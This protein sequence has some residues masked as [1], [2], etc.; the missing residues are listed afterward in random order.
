MCAMG[1]VGIIAEYNPFHSGHEYHIAETRRRLGADV[2]VVAVMSGNWVQR[3]ECAIADKWLRARWAVLGG[4]DLV[5]EL[6]TVFAC[7]PAETFAGSAVALLLATGVVDQ[8][9]FG[10]EAGSGEAL[11]EVARCLN[12]REYGETL[13]A[14]RQTPSRTFAQCRQKAVESLLGEER[15]ILLS[16]PNCNLA[17]EYLRRCEEMLTPLAI[18]RAGAGHDAEDT[19]QGHCSASALRRML[20]GGS[21][22]TAAPFLPYV[23]Q[24]QPSDM[25]WGERAVLAKLRTMTERAWGELL[26]S[27]EKEGLPHRLARGAEQSGTL[28]EFYRVVKTKRYT[29]ARIRRLTLHAFLGLTQAARDPQYLRVL[30]FNDRG[31]ALLAQMRHTARLPVVTKPARVR[32]MTAAARESFLQEAVFTDLYGLFFPQVKPGGAEWRNSPCY[33]REARGEQTC[34]DE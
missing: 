28:E 15:G 26:D 12:S 23:W 14:L 21:G 19:G 8:L 31:R 22:H 9:S 2:P 30:A 20:R 4:A 27:G 34:E 29:H 5:L 16:K 11:R 1:A 33:R 17:V 13:A 10:C 32:A 3:G 18:A 7:A 6:P 24:G 25:Q